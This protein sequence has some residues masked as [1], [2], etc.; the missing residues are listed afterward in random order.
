MLTDFSAAFEIPRIPTLLVSPCLTGLLLQ[1]S[2]FPVFS[3]YSVQLWNFGKPQPWSWALLFLICILFLA[4]LSYGPMCLNINYV[5]MTFLLTHSLSSRQWVLVFQLVCPLEHLKIS[6]TFGLILYIQCLTQINAW[7]IASIWT[8][9]GVCVHMY[10]WTHIL[11]S[12]FKKSQ[13]TR[14]LSSYCSWVY[15]TMEFILLFFKSNI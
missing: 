10:V 11:Q 4:H 15:V 9:K 13:T 5:Q 2:L 8:K 12:P 3:S 14:I 7:H 1:H 6:Q